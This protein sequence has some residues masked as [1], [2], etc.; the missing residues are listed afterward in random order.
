MIS[1]HDIR[2]IRLGTS[3]LDDSVRYA[4]RILGLELVRRD[5]TSAH[6]RADDRDHTLAYVVGNPR[7]H[8]AAFELR[9]SAELESAAAELEN[10]GRAVRA[11]TKTECEQRCVDSFVT[12]KD[13]SGNVI[14]LVV[15]P[16]HSGRR[17]FP[18][19]DAGITGFSHIGL[20]SISPRQD[21][22]FWTTVCNARV[23][24]WIGEAPLLRIDPVH[25]RIALFPS[26]RTGVQHIN[27]QVESIDDIMRS[28][29]FLKEQNVRIRFGP[30]RHPTSGAM[31][32]Y[33]EG[34]DEMIYE[35][36][37]GVRMITDEHYLPRKFPPRSS[38]FCAWGSKPDIPEFEAAARDA[39]E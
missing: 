11:G 29:Y 1:L 12:F 4:T 5:S 15:R 16:A 20:H 3:N 18:S 19:R 27:H 8:V 25:H 28:Y 10:S 36:S 24:D 13:P 21:E 33:F 23:S 34:P 31:F 37:S 30:G 22:I 32:L 7:D 17:Y 2:Y 35:Y 6:L 38:S 26:K 14:E 39:N 9:T